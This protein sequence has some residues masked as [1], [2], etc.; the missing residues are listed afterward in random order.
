MKE[1]IKVTTNDK[2]QQLVSARELHEFLEVKSRFN[3]WITNRINKYE[4]VE[5]E[6]YIAITKTLVTAQGNKSNYLDYALT[7]DMAKELSKEEFNEIMMVYKKVT[8]RLL[9]EAEKQGMDI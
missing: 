4:F 6:D 3:D 8:D 1:L 7:I 5:F 9:A 2:G